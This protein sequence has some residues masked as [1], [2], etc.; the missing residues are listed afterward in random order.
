MPRLECE[1]LEQPRIPDRHWVHLIE[2]AFL[3]GQIDSDKAALAYLFLAYQKQLF[4]VIAA[5]RSH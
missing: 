5:D 3:V 2:Q 4:Q 1:R